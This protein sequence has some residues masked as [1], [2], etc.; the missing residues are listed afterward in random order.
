[1]PRLYSL[2]RNRLNLPA[3]DHAL[4][5]AVVALLLLALSGEVRGALGDLAV[6]VAQVAGTGGAGPVR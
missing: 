1:M 6:E 3:L 5:V 2:L 4:L